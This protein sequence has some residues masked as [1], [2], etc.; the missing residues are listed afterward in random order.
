M[1]S[2]KR[3]K[4][5]VVSRGRKVGERDSEAIKHIAE[6][7][8]RAGK[9]VHVAA[10]IDVSESRISEFLSGSR[11][12]SPEAM[13]KLAKLAD[14]YGLPSTFFFLERAGVDRQLLESAAAKIIEARSLLVGEIQA[15]PRIRETP[16][17]MVQDG[18]VG[19]STAYISSPL[20]T[21]WLVVGEDLACGPF[22]ADDI[23]KVENDYGDAS[24]ERFHNGPVVLA[25]F[26]DEEPERRL[27][28]LKGRA[29]GTFMR[30]PGFTS[31]VPML[32]FAPLKG[33]FNTNAV[34]GMLFPSDMRSGLD[35]ERLASAIARENVELRRVRII[36]RVTGW[37]AST[38][39]PEK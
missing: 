15:I 9:R 1:T 36:G 19:V 12:P 4:E 27:F 17:A 25:E 37:L 6:L 26:P 29:I 14:R 3:P 20:S 32:E 7:V 39:H 21:I 33:E 11:L 5:Q 10:A 35:G 38:P 16:E 28:P 18:A 30:R 13:V 22:K 31:S 8:K 2:Q 34:I 24:E 23:I